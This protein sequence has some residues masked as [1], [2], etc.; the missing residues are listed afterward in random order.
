MNTLHT[1]WLG[2]VAYEDGLAL[3]NTAVSHRDDDPTLPDQLYLLEHPHTYTLGRGGDWDNLLINEAQLA[4][5]HISVHHIKRG[6]DITYHGPGQL[7]GYPIFNMT[8]LNKRLGNRPLD[9]RAFVTNIE[10]CLIQ[11]LAQFGIEGWRDARYPGVW[12][13]TDGGRAKIAAIG[14][15]INRNRISSHGFALNVQPDMHYFDH[16]IP[17]GIQEFKVTSMA[18]MLKRPLTVQDVLP[19]VINAV[20][21]VFRYEQVGEAE[22]EI[23]KVMGIH[24][25]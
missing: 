6:G 25:G 20:Q 15:H 16:I 4:K 24:E 3:Q 22:R 11:V 23:A 14:I 5:K 2:L 17:C 19:T 12:V 7:V 13:D 10:A 8:R 9:V 18:E 1:N 21:A